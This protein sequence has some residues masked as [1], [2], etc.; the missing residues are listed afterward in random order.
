MLSYET[1]PIT[2]NTRFCL[3][4]ANKPYKAGSNVGKINV[5]TYCRAVPD[6]YENK[7]INI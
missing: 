1:K 5:S 3:A 6:Y 2:S 4:S 7:K